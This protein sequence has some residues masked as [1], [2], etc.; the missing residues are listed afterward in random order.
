MNI[1]LWI[2]QGLLAL[3]FFYSGITKG[4]KPVPE[5][6]KMGQ[7][8]VQ[9]LSDRFVHSIGIAELLG[10]IGII[11][12]WVLQAAPV[13]TPISALCF[14]LVMVCSIPIH[15]RQKNYFQ[16]FTHLLI[17]AVALFVAINRFMQL[18]NA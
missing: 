6:V 16:V 11:L 14:A 3:I 8:G 4:F 9:G 5:L 2:C 12:P 15:F 7:T 10:V 17:L 13:L 18:P 1:A